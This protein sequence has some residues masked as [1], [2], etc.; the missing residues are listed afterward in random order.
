MTATATDAR[1]G[2][3]NNNNNNNLY[4]QLLCCCVT[5]AS[6]IFHILTASQAELSQKLKTPM[7][8]HPSRE[9]ERRRIY[10]ISDTYDSYN[11]TLSIMLDTKEKEIK[12]AVTSQK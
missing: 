1:Q 7:L 9:Q 12:G 5:H 4:R 8:Q 11:T 10:N 6:H 3:R 2:I